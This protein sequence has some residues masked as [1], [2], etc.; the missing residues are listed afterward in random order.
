MAYHCIGGA[1]RGIRRASEPRIGECSKRYNDLAGAPI[2]CGVVVRFD[3]FGIL[4]SGHDLLFGQ[5]RA[6]IAFD[7]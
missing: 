7:Q 5:P 1:G 6:V 3:R 2:L 4:Q